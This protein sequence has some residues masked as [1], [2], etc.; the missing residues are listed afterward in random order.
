MHLAVAR[1][2]SSATSSTASGARAAARWKPSGLRSS[3]PMMLLTWMP[4]PG[5]TTP[6]P[7]PFVHV[8]A[9]ARP[10][11][12]TTEMCVVDPMR[13]P[14][15]RGAKPGSPS[16]STNCR[17]ALGLGRLHRADDRRERR[18][19]AAPG[20]AGAATSAQQDAARRRRRVRQ[21]VAPAVAHVERL[22]RD[23]L[24]AAQVRGGEHAAA[25]TDVR[26][27][28][29]GDVALVERRRALGAEALD[30]VAQLRAAAHSPSSSSGPRGRTAP[31]LRRR[32]QDRLEQAHDLR[33]LRVERRPARASA[34]AGAA[35]SA[36]GSEP[37]RA[38]AA[39][40][41]AGLPYVPHDAGADVEDLARVAAKSTSTGTSSARGV[42]VRAEARRGDE[43][44]QQHGLLARAGDEHVAPGSRPA[45]QR[46][47]DPR[48]EHRRDRRVDGVAA[49][50][51]R[52]DARLRGERVARGH[53]AL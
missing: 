19:R 22:A 4:V 23:R 7:S 26:G 41:P 47:G 38:I 37:Q 1:R 14:S 13:E 6:E 25:R 18:R 51:Q 50:P 28:R 44:V 27:D 2:R 8:T 30:R 29:V 16:P 3:S 39:S 12:S 42:A 40:T 46:L 31:R 17:R 24:V 35:S 49:R 48:H 36:S 20:R 45:Q 34:A 52:V 10:A 11:A 5:T 53:D 21:H 32:A 9:H 33:L 43:E 15:R